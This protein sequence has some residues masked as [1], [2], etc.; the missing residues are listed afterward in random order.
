MFRRHTAL[1]LVGQG[2][3]MDE[4]YPVRGVMKVVGQGT[5]PVVAPKGAGIVGN[6]CRLSIDCELRS[7]KEPIRSG[8]GSAA[9]RNGLMLLGIKPAIRNCLSIVY[10][11]NAFCLLLQHNT[12]TEKNPGPT[13][14][15]GL[16][17]CVR[18]L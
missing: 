3:N 1:H 17:F 11:L 7:T 13:S 16:V 2:R 4:A 10:Y 8:S 9:I 15:K 5:E 12:Q 6:P 14:P 18:L